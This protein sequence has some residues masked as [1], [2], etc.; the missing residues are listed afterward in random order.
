MYKVS[1]I[2][3]RWNDS[4]LAKAYRLLPKRIRSR[5]LSQIFFTFLSSVIELTTLLVV[6]KF[7]ETLTSHGDQVK[8]FDLTLLGWE[9]RLSFSGLYILVFSYLLLG[10][11]VRIINQLRLHGLTK[12]TEDELA[13]KFYRNFFCRDFAWHKMNNSSEMVKSVMQDANLLTSGFY[14][15]SV[16]L[17][18]NFMIIVGLLSIFLIVN[19]SV[20]IYIIATAVIF[21]FL[22]RVLTK[23]RLASYGQKKASAAGSRYKHIA[24]SVNALP[25]IYV[26]D[27]LDNYEGRFL[28]YTGAYT[29]AQRGY[30]IISSV[31]TMFVESVSLIAVTVFGVFIVDEA[32]DPEVLAQLMFG[33][34]CATRLIPA[35]NRIFQAK[36]TITFTSVFVEQNADSHRGTAPQS[37]VKIFQ[38]TEKIRLEYA[39]YAIGN[40]HLCP[41]ITCDLPR[42]ERILIKGRSGSGKSTLIEM[43]CG[44]LVPTQGSV[45]IDGH[46]LNTEF[47]SSWQQQIAYLPQRSLI[48]DASIRENITGATQEIPSEQFETVV[49]MLGLNIIPGGLDRSCG[50]DG[51]AISGGQRQRIALARMLLS[52]KE[53][54]IMDEATNSLDAEAEI[55]LMQKVFAFKS[56]AT[57]LCISHRPD[58]CAL[59]DRVIDMEAL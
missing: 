18:S 36:S 33:V 15:A 7:L 52:Q 13:R 4:L 1:G 17:L 35:V 45:T 16:N 55:E 43:I 50:E 30:L 21:Y 38:F 6:Y 42:G 37:A 31:P 32:V 44:L 40:A 3:A 23:E 59:F 49:A 11:V 5:Y 27:Q 10:L 2:R 24:E 46:P 39:S 41:P 48:K 53:V 8:L 56:Q 29:A 22:L 51:A 14:I 57:F 12:A 58:V 9:Y 25:E 54:I 28:S 47:V 34:V 19:F 26:D 20:S